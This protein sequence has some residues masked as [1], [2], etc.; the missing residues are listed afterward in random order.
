MK[1]RFNISGLHL[2]TKLHLPAMPKLPRWCALSLLAIWLGVFF[3]ADQLE[4]LLVT[5]PHQKAIEQTLNQ[6][7]S[8][9]QRDIDGQI[10]KLQDKTDRLASDPRTLQILLSPRQAATSIQRTARVPDIMT[11]YEAWRFSA[12]A[13]IDGAERVFLLQPGNDEFPIPDNFVAELLYREA[14]EGG[15]PPPRSARTSRWY[16]Y[17]ARPVMDG[18]KVAGC[19]LVEAQPSVLLSTI[20]RRLADMGRI[21]INQK[22]GDFPQVSFYSRG[23]GWKEE[24]SATTDTSLPGWLIHF[25]GS[26]SLIDN[27]KPSKLPYVG[28]MFAAIAMALALSAY[29]ILNYVQ[30]PATAKKRQ[31]PSRH[32]ARHNTA[33]TGHPG[34]SE[35]DSHADIAGLDAI[36]E[37]EERLSFPHHV[38]RDYD[39]RGRADTEL[40]GDFATQLGKVIGNMVLEDGEDQLVV[41]S[42][43]RLS[44]PTL[45]AAF[46]RG[47]ISTGCDLLDL[48]SAPTPV[49]NFA[50]STLEDYH[51]GVMITASHNP[52]EDNGFKI[53]LNH[54]VLSSDR[55]AGLYQR[56]TE[57]QPTR[58][59]GQMHRADIRSQYIERIVDDILPPGALRIAV[60]CAN[61]IAGDLAPR[62]F[63][64]LGCEVLCLFSDIDGSFP[65]H[66]PDP[67]VPANLRAL[68]NVVRENKLD[69]GFAFDGDGDRVVAVSGSGR[70]VWPDELLM[71]FARDIVTRNPGSDVIFDVKSTGRLRPLITSYGG[72]PVM[73]KT[74][75]AHI[76]NKVEQ[77][78]APL[79]G[80]FSG[81]IFF[82]D[83]WF[84]FDD[85]LYT[86]A[87]LLEILSLREQSLDE[88]ISSFP[89]VCATEEIKIP[90]PEIR[91]NLLMWE[92]TENCDFGDADV[93]KIDGLRVEY[94]YGWGLVRA[95]NTTAALTLRFEA[96][97]PE[98]LD[99][100]KAD[101]RKRL[102]A[103][104]GNLAL[105]F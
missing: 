43:G 34:K 27:A 41:C 26:K 36:P 56:M 28:A 73:W 93:L 13:Q 96:D 58:A 15:R 72:R 62:L 49:M 8:L 103:V 55:V 78:E 92:L 12:K 42:D 11:P 17:I 46:S 31:G 70:I 105:D 85:G 22:A 65:N 57:V 37:D 71:I 69:L 100:I 40:T 47:V 20:D 3:G 90:V 23:A 32:H 99:A 59:P 64:L 74:G 53:V 25:T 9:F 29:L 38:F 102:N 89:E 87:R 66:P 81:H 18:D 39:I 4:R 61:G 104:D 6:S 14:L 35:F 5:D 60:D 83:R 52:A 50:L 2:G 19:L 16:I 76:R 44:S 45:K 82:R 91:K 54:R 77:S 30:M 24:Y 63:P 21:S 1:Q 7:L 51:S 79:G 67:T 84:G 88:I 10:S 80:E 75:H 86:A 68:I 94:E 97:T 33:R 48:G 95:S 98:H 101:F